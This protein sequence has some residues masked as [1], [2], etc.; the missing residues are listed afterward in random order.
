MKTNQAG[1]RHVAE[2]E[3]VDPEPG[4]SQWLRQSIGFLMNQLARI[5]RTQTAEGL[6]PLEISPR[7]LGILETIAHHGELTQQETGQRLGIDRTSMMQYTDRLEALGLVA[8]KTNPA[9]RRSHLLC[10]TPEGK[11]RLEQARDI[12][13]EKQE[14]FMEPLNEAER[15]HLRGLLQKLLRGQIDEADWG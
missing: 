13:M 14:A 9:D 8:R 5:I 12:A 2:P 1:T 6:L 4:E 11:A 10:L 3:C 7:H 15:E